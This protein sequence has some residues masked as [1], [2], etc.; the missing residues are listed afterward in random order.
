[1]V[2]NWLPPA[3]P[4]GVILYY[5]VSITL[6]SNGLRILLENTTATT[7]TERNLGEKSYNSVTSPQ[8]GGGGGGTGA[9]IPLPAY[10][11][12]IFNFLCSPWN[13]L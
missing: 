10:S 13:S 4:N 1:M 11:L 3:S 6:H 12:P 5:T 9:G 2:L 8:L 7:Y